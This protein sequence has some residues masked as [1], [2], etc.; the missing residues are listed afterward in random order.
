MAKLVGQVRGRAGSRL[1]KAELKQRKDADR[2]NSESDR[3]AKLDTMSPDERKEFVG[4]ESS[5]ISL[6]LSRSLP[7]ACLSRHSKPR[8]SMGAEETH[9][10][11]GLMFQLCLQHAQYRLDH[12]FLPLCFLFLMLFSHPALAPALV[13]RGGVSRE[14]GEG[15][16]RPAAQAHECQLLAGIPERE[17]GEVQVL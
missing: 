4:K 16:A 7:H 5:L 14:L 10:G 13:G 12:I 15:P 11:K 9:V 6:S 3:K 8:V 17:A 2:E 1:S